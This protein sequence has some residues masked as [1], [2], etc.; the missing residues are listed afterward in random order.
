M[1]VRWVM[2]RCEP[3]REDDQE[4]D[5]LI[6]SEMMVNRSPNLEEKSGDQNTT[7]VG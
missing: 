3:G 6:V 7:H 5:G 1:D 2:E 4:S